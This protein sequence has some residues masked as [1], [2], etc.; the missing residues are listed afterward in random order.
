L[1][2]IVYSKPN[3]PGCDTLKAKLKAEG[4]EFVEIELGKDMSIEAF[5]EKFPTVRS[6]PYM[7]Y[8]KDTTW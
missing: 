2:T 3:C 5:K 1:K 6:V 4:V 8:T 7:E